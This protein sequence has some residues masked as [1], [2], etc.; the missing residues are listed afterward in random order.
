MF[1]YFFLFFSPVFSC[2]FSCFFFF[3]RS[4]LLEAKGQTASN[5]SS[6]A[7][8]PLAGPGK[9]PARRGSAPTMTRHNTLM[10]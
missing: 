6:P 4:E 5:Q 9:K 8:N 3:L 1:I 2:F 7:E 10:W